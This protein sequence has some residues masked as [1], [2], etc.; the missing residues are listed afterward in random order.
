M[1]S[2]DTPGPRKP[3]DG[4]RLALAPPDSTGTLR[5]DVRVTTFMVSRN[6]LSTDEVPPR[7]SLQALADSLRAACRGH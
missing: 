3:L 6:G 1:R 2:F 4:L 5:L 7:P